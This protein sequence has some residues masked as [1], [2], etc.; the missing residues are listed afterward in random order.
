MEKVKAWKDNYFSQLRQ[1]RHQYSKTNKTGSGNKKLS[2]DGCASAMLPR[3]PCARPRF[4]I[5]LF[6]AV[7]DYKGMYCMMERDGIYVVK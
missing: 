6:G 4:F 2:I 1:T 5:A 7:T 3:R